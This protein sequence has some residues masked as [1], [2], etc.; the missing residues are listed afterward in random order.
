MYASSI[1]S[2][3]QNQQNYSAETIFHEDLLK[4]PIQ[5][6]RVNYIENE[7]FKLLTFLSS[8]NTV[9]APINVALD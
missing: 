5:T 4:T 1:L 9:H 6:I 2:Y 3:L 7:E 8:V